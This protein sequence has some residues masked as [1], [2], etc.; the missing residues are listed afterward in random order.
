M[1]N[2][3]FLVPIAMV[4]LFFVS[5]YMLLDARASVVEKYEITLEAARDY[6]EQ[7][8][9]V[10][11]QAQYLSAYSQM[12]SAELAMEISEFYEKSYNKGQAIGWLETAINTHNED[13]FLYEELMRLYYENQDFVACYKVFDLLQ[14][15][16]LSSDYATETEEKI[17][18]T[19]YFNSNFDE[20]V[21]YSEGLIP[22]KVKEMWGYANT[23]GSKVIANSFEKVGA[24]SDGLAPVVDNDGDA[25]FIDT[26]GNKK[27]VVIGVEGVKELGLIANN[28][29]ALYNGKSW[30]FYNTNNEYVFGDYEKVSSLGNGIAAVMNNYKWNLVNYNGISVTNDEYDDVIMDEKSIVYRN[31]RIFVM[32]GSMYSMIDATGNVIV[33]QQ[34]Q[35]ARLFNDGSY[36]AVKVDGKWGF[37]DKDGTIVIEPQY[38]EARSF[39]NGLAAVRF[40]GFWG[41]INQEGEMVIKPA[42]DDA[43]DFNSN[44]CVFVLRGEQWELLRLYKYNH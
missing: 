33:K 36:A 42:F 20:V 23:T 40:G 21:V 43:K 39:M 16:K 10:D 13:V 24:F 44:G 5:G 17:A 3:K 22:I 4:V 32:Q 34:Y 29:F 27:K 25:Y 9:R 15:R 35:D 18:Y 26:N 19:Y 30:A 28:M 31:D 41:F 37:I 11:A 8:I 12:P 1:S 38:E 14:K 2:Y 7:D 6:R